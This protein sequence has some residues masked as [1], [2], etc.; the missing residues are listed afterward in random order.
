MIKVKIIFYEKLKI[1]SKILILWKKLMRFHILKILN[2]MR[3]YTNFCRT[4]QMFFILLSVQS[5]NKFPS[6]IP[7]TFKFSFQ[8]LP[9]LLFFLNKSVCIE[10]HSNFELNFSCFSLPLLG[11]NIAFFGTLAEHLRGIFRCQF[12]C[13]HN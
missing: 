1:L 12:L 13:L 8:T 2:L 4:F 6:D 7:K 10:Y 9:T 5:S 3:I 11:F